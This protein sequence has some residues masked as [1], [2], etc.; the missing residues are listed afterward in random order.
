MAYILGS[1]Q[2]QYLTI[3]G[4][5]LIIFSSNDYLGLSH[6]PDVLM[7]AKEALDRF[8][9]GTG[10]APGTSGTT[11]IHENLAS[12]IAR[13]KNR[14]SGVVFPS[15]YAANAAIHHSLAEKNAVF[16]YDEKSHPSA[17]DGIRLSRCDCEPFG[18]LDFDHLENLLKKS[19]H[20]RK[21]VSVCSVFTIDGV[22]CPLNRLAGLKEKYDFILILDEAHATGCI[23]ETGR[24]LEELYSLEGTADF[25]MG[26]FSKA[27]GSQGG[28]IAFSKEAEHFL[29]RYFRPFEYSTA[30]SAPVAAASLKALFILKNQPELVGKMKANIDNIY[31]RLSESGFNLNEPGRHIVN[32]YFDSEK[33]TLAVRDRLFESG[34]FVIPINA[35]SRHGLRLTA[36]TVHSENEIDSFCSALIDIKKS[37]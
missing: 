34:Y 17:V 9:S 29:C 8:G 7:A 23:G 36:M 10:G 33:Q 11:E 14:H 22:I 13:F 28:F 20:A 18:H 25:I 32:V 30:I 15:G 37:L 26:T 1:R 19:H 21:I 35:G 27:L 5:K 12:E 16:F 6:N 4:R 24:G 3:K 2:A 31:H